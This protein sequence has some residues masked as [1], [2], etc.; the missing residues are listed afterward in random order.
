MKKINKTLLALS[1]LVLFTQC[2][3]V[4]KSLE[5]KK[6]ELSNQVKISK[7]S[8]DK[9]D[10][11][12]VVSFDK[13]DPYAKYFLSLDT[14]EYHLD[15]DLRY[16]KKFMSFFNDPLK[17]YDLAKKLLKYNLMSQRK[18]QIILMS[19]YSL[20]L[21]KRL[22]LLDYSYELFKQ[23]IFDSTTLN[24]SI[25]CPSFKNKPIFY[26]DYK[27]KD[28]VKTLKEIKSN[29]NVK[30]NVKTRIDMIISGEMYNKGVQQ[31]WK[32]GQYKPKNKK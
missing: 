10:K 21:D 25:A 17:E 26:I 6:S 3:K 32:W 18:K 1:T 30:N 16:D 14:D 23:E 31:D 20:P 9:K 4:E 29:K 13:S 12:E 7:T 11:L 2:N 15:F 28:L 8:D 27:N 5:S 22:E 19:M 24:Y